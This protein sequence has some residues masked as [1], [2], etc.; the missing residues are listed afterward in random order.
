MA[1]PKLKEL[2]QT[3]DEFLHVCQHDESWKDA[4]GSSSVS[5]DLEFT[6]TESYEQAI[7]LAKH[8]Y[9]EGVQ[10]IKDG[11][12][13]VKAKKGLQIEC[14][15]D[16]T[17][18]EACIDRYLGNDPENMVNYNYTVQGGIKFLD[19]YFSI[20]YSCRHEQ[21]EII[22]RGVQVLSNIDSLENNNYRVRIIAYHM[23]TGGR[24]RPL[25]HEIIVKDYQE[26]IELDRMAFIMVNPSMLRRLG[27]RITEI[28]APAY[29]RRN[30]GCS[31]SYPHSIDGVDIHDDCFSPDNIDLR[32][33]EYNCT[34]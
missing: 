20:G 25:L 17:G 28:Y 26:P 5:G 22:K 10:W 6:G 19:V 16:V 24:N 27:F 18:D 1:R 12:D 8:G 32:F 9:P 29:T 30:Y 13:N 4:P 15:F 14:S 34:E 23:T 2:K 33:K 7:D 21:P 31:G 3:F 11:L